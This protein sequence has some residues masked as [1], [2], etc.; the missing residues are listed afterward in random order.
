M[1]LQLTAVR[2]GLQLNK[3]KNLVSLSRQ[4]TGKAI[5]MVQV[6]KTAQVLLYIFFL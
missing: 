6:Q 4:I 2:L 1:I 3:T 5:Y